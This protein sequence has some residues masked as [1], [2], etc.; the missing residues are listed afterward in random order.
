MEKLN[1]NIFNKS[2]IL[3]TYTPPP[4]RDHY[5]LSDSPDS[6]NTL[7]FPVKDDDVILVA[8]DGVFDKVPKKLLLDNGFLT[9]VRQ[10]RYNRQYRYSHH[11]SYKTDN[12]HTIVAASGVVVFISPTQY[13]AVACTY[14]YKKIL[15]VLSC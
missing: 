11:N 12:S 2:S 5:V 15:C 8:A 10:G 4:G 9:I 13:S 6:A 3:Q 1:Y 14:Y 7:N